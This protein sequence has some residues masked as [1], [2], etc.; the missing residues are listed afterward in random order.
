MIF[1]DLKDWIEF[2]I[3]FNN[4]DAGKHKAPDPQ[5]CLQLSVKVGQLAAA[6]SVPVSLLGFLYVGVELD[7]GVRTRGCVDLMSKLAVELPGYI[8][9]KGEGGLLAELSV[10]EGEETRLLFY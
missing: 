4:R 9:Q 1:V 5:P 10:A 7:E 8:L 2:W 3:S 6:P